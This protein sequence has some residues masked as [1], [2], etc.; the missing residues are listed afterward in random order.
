MS[1]YDFWW[2][3]GRGTENSLAWFYDN[4]QDGFNDFLILVFLFGFAYWIFTLNKLL[5]KAKNDPN[6]LE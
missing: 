5:K 2:A 6:Q 1:S 4:V 3:V